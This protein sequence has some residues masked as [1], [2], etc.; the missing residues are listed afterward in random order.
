MIFRISFT[1]TWF[2]SLMRRRFILL[3]SQGK[4]NE[5]ELF[6][7][8]L[9]KE[10]TPSSLMDDILAIYCGEVK[11]CM[12]NHSIKMLY[13]LHNATLQNGRPFG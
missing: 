9:L 8:V 5:A 2:S 13:S 6:V 4:G 12:V 11:W 3:F 10:K 7:G 1:L